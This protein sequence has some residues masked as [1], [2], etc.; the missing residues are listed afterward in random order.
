MSRSKRSKPI[1]GITTA[2]SEKEWKRDTNRKLLRAVHRT[3]HHF[4]A[5]GL[6]GLVL[7]VM[8]EVANHY[9]GPKDGKQ[10]FDPRQDPLMRK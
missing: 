5:A 9:S 7:P 10:R 4:S 6:E 1:T 8:D 3:L 2:E